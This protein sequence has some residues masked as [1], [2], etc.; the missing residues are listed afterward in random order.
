MQFIDRYTILG[1][2]NTAGP[3]S[4]VAV[5]HVS[6]MTLLYVWPLFSFKKQTKT[7]QQQKKRRAGHH[8]CDTSY[9]YCIMGT[10]SGLYCLHLLLMY[11]KLQIRCL[12]F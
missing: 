2:F 10:L 1:H 9:K 4:H 12:K 5:P 11:F 3:K 8:N 7:K 6:M